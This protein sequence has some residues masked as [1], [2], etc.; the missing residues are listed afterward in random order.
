MNERDDNGAHLGELGSGLNQGFAQY[1][2]SLEAVASDL[3][4]CPALGVKFGE[5]QRS[6]PA[7]YMGEEATT[8]GITHP[9]GKELQGLSASEGDTR[10]YQFIE[11]YQE[12]RA[13]E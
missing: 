1:K 7:I 10:Q 12:K 13:E 11:I 3:W 8:A 2:F 4:S 5:A 6:K 9:W